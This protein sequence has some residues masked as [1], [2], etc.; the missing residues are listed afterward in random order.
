[1]N[2]EEINFITSPSYILAWNLFRAVKAVRQRR[3]FPF[4]LKKGLYS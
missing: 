1:M 4:H 2:R 3:E